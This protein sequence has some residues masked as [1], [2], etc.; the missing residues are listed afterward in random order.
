[1][2]AALFMS[3]SFVHAQQNIDPSFSN[4]PQVEVADTSTEREV[5]IIPP[6]VITIDPEINMNPLASYKTVEAS[7]KKGQKLV[8]NV[9]VSWHAWGIAFSHIWSSCPS[10]LH[11]PVINCSKNSDDC[12]FYTYQAGNQTGECTV[13]YSYAK[14]FYYDTCIHVTVE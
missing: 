10:W 7:L 6:C 9:P 1:M 14:H 12:N 13:Y 11:A 3:H 8:V 5:D 4:I 2:F